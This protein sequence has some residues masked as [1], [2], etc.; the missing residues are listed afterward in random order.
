ME[1][2]VAEGAWSRS[3]REEELVRYRCGRKRGKGRKGD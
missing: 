3:S 1:M 2:E